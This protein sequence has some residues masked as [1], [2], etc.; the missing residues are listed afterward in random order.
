MRAEDAKEY[1]KT[2]GK[3]GMVLGL[4]R[5]RR[6][7]EALGSP[8]N[9]LKF[10][11]VAGTNGKG[12]VIAYLSSILK[13]AGYRTGAYTSP[14]VFDEM[15]VFRINDVPMARKTYARLMARIK[16]VMERMEQQGDD[17]PTLFEV[18]T[19]LAF[20]YF[21]EERCDIV[22][23]EAGLGGGLDATNCIK[24][25]LCA[26]ITSI[27]RDH[28]AVLGNTLGEIAGQKAGIIK[29]AEDCA[30][31]KSCAACGETTPQEAGYKPQ[32]V[33]AP[34]KEEVLNVLKQVCREKHA[35]L[36]VADRTHIRGN[37]LV[38]KTFPPIRLIPLGEHQLEN[39]AIAIE[40]IEKLRNLHYNIKDE[41]VVCGLRMAKWP[42]RLTILGREPLLVMDGAHN[43]QAARCLRRALKT[44][45]S[46]MEWCFIMGV[47]ADKEYQKIISHM[48]PLAT[49]IYTITPDNPRALSGELLAETIHR[50]GYPA[51]C[52]ASV[53]EAQKEALTWCKNGKN[54]GVLAF[55]SFTFL[56]EWKG[57]VLKQYPHA[58]AFSEGE[59]MEK[60]SCLTR[61]PLFLEKMEQLKKLEKNRQFCKHDI[62]HCLDV[63]RGCVILNE[64]RMLGFS[65]E[66][67]YALAL[68]HDIGRAEQYLHEIPHE[69]ASA[70]LAERIL[71]DC[72]FEKAVV[73]QMI[74]AIRYHRGGN[75]AGDVLTALLIEADKRTR[76][77]FACE[78]R[79]ECNWPE[80][81]KND[82]IYI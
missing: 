30:G 44:E 47:L 56:K 60:V 2:I 63:A 26:V 21:K 40:V 68:V 74:K 33:S 10:V 17:L 67:L 66:M 34:Q 3:S 15:E 42:G 38:Y 23:L 4:E 75:D 72:G 13:A 58:A 43:E 62:Q 24:T 78:A 49:V 69:E 54:R 81:R 52:Q 39:A 27:S 64:E 20:L 11:H 7:L 6:L 19:A 32:V 59:R 77:C 51:A 37:T 41:H 61:H 18:E 48:A 65:R 14:A 28:T 35:E 16:A 5:I 80:E 46:D 53:T 29:A 8:Q 73:R 76:I 9:D 50:M 25:P 82:R 70:Q 36:C 57:S 79:M 12:S 31:D 71:E 45:F 1:A 22:L 55:G